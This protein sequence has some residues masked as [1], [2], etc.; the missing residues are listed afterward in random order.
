M[1]ILLIEDNIDHLELI[2]SM[3]EGIAE[4]EST[5]LISNL[6]ETIERVKP[7]ILLCD[8]FLVDATSAMT[9]EFLTNVYNQLPVI[10]LTSL[11]NEELGVEQVRLGAQDYI[12][13]SRLDK[14]LL[15][16]TIQYAIERFSHIRE[17]E[18]LNEKLSV[19]TK[20]VCHDFSTPLRSM[21]SYLNYFIDEYRDCLPE[22]AVK[23]LEH[24]ESLSK[25]A[26]ETLDDLYD[27]STSV[28]IKKELSPIEL[29]PLVE[30]VLFDLKSRIIETGANITFSQLGS[31]RSSKNELAVIF[32]NIISNAMKFPKTED[33]PVI[34]IKGSQLADD[35]YRVTICDHGQGIDPEDQAKIFEPFYIGHSKS[36]VKGTG[37]GLATTKRLCDY[38]SIDISLESELG[39]GTSFHFDFKK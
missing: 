25:R 3:L 30:S 6:Q 7:D 32:Q 31:V 26:H 19:F 20:M 34:T 16:K 37:L 21:E 24:I 11:T 2:E 23:D 28:G 17:L 8:L 22:Q 14:V 33:I 4:I 1:K 29:H 27:F 13:K 5:G 9:L 38:L 35:V 10:I 36:S 12:E 39:N 15:Q 18:S